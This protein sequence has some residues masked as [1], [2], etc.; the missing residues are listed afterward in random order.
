M[1]GVWRPLLYA[2]VMAMEEDCTSL[3]L[4]RDL[5]NGYFAIAVPA[6]ATI[7]DWGL[8]SQ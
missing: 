2:A 1:P 8:S 6:N 4:R 7:W 3:C 5:G